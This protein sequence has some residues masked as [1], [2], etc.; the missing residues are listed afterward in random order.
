VTPEA[1]RTKGELH[2]MVVRILDGMTNR[3]GSR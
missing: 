2:A 1:W 3:V